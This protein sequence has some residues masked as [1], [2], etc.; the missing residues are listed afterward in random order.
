MYEQLYCRLTT[1][2]FLVL[3]SS[4][5]VQFAYN[6][7]TRVYCLQDHHIIGTHGG[8]YSGSGYARL[9]EPGHL[10]QVRVFPLAAILK[11]FT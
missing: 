6:V 1:V 9:P 2:V 8:Q 10:R 3:F 11:F 4:D 5:S 7:F